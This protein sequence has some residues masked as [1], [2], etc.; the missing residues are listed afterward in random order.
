MASPMRELYEFE[1]VSNP[2]HTYVLN[3]LNYIIITIIMIIFSM[4]GLAGTAYLLNIIPGGELDSILILI[5]SMPPSLLG[6]SI[7]YLRKLYLLGFRL[8]ESPR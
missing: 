6:S 5:L 7:R 2:E 8:R 3:K 1:G 4:L